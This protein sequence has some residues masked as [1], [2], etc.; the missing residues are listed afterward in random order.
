MSPELLLL[1][2]VSFL[3]PV[4]PGCFWHHLCTWAINRVPTAYKDL[5]KTLLKFWFAAWFLLSINWYHN[6]IFFL[7]LPKMWNSGSRFCSIFCYKFWAD[8]H[9]IIY[10][11]HQELMELMESNDNSCCNMWWRW[12][13]DAFKCD[14]LKVTASVVQFFG[15]VNNPWFR[16]F[17]ILEIK[18][19][20]VFGWVV[21]L[22]MQ[23]HEQCSRWISLD[24]H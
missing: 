2:L 21:D 17:I 8:Y 9:I 18:R 16:A 12:W 19:V 10:I 23:F 5:I 20:F 24:V 4:G 6:S 1:K 13:S 14:T 7:F 11:H 22:Q 15:F 3:R